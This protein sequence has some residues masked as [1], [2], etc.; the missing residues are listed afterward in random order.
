ME[1][2]KRMIRK[3]EYYQALLN[4]YERR[5][6]W[7]GEYDITDNALLSLLTNI[8]K[9]KDG[10][11]LDKTVKLFY[12]LKS[13]VGKQLFSYGTFEN[14]EISFFS[15]RLAAI[16][17]P[18]VL[19]IGANIGVHTVGWAKDNPQMRICA[20]EPSPV[21]YKV[22]NKNI[23]LNKITGQVETF[24][25]AVSNATETRSFYHAEDDAYS[26]LKDTKRKAVKDIFKIQT[27][28]LDDFVKDKRLDKIDFIKIDVEG[29]EGE[30]I[31]GATQTLSK[32][33]PDLFVE[34][35][36]GTDSNA[37]PEK[38]IKTLI[39]MGY[40]AYIF[41]DGKLRPFSTHDDRY[42]NYYFTFTP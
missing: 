32:L 6:R 34:I 29:F 30:V 9:I 3:F 33:R 17:Q 28:T 25:L 35:Y 12:Q 42:Y 31:E 10:L 14:G 23:E 1:I 16:N 18:V 26:S 13:D 5:R 40:K 22:L 11:I 20:F 27:T 19:D 41:I 15:Q 21:T 37:A 8:E 38:T 36:K 2:L 4:V 39:N 24:L 7:I